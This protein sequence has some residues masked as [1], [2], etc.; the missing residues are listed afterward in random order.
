VTPEYK[1]I[2]VKSNDVDVKDMQY[3][4]S[5]T[6]TGS[7]VKIFISPDS[8]TTWYSYVNNIW[9]SYELTNDNLDLYGMTIAELNAINTNFNTFI[10]SKFRFAFLVANGF[11][12]DNL[13]YQLDLKGTWE[14]GV[15]VITTYEIIYGNES[16]TIKLSNPGSYKIN[17]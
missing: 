4:D 6:L 11:S 5:I 10:T 8:G 7:D 17:Y 15:D 14:G 12:V 16:I 2:L 1:Q 3:I 13:A 9:T